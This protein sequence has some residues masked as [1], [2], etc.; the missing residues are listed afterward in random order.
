LDESNTVKLDDIQSGI[1][2]FIN[3]SDYQYSIFIDGEWGIGK[4][5]FIRNTLKSSLPDNFRYVYVSLFGIASI[6]ELD[7]KISTELLLQAFDKK[8]FCKSKLGKLGIMLGK[9]SI[10]IIL[11]RLALNS[12][13]FP[14]NSE[15]ASLLPQKNDRKF[16]F[17]FDDIERASCQIKD[18]FGYI[19]N[20]I[21]QYRAKVL[22]IGCQPKIGFTGDI[23]E[24]E[25]TKEHDDSSNNSNS[26]Q[27][28]EQN[29]FSQY[30]EKLIGYKIDFKPDF[31]DV[32]KIFVQSISNNLNIEKEIG[33]SS[34]E[35]TEVI[36]SVFID[37]NEYNLRKFQSVIGTIGRLFKSLI[38]PKINELFSDQ[39][40]KKQF[41][42]ISIIQIAFSKLGKKPTKRWTE[43]NLLWA[44]QLRSFPSYIDSFVKS[45]IMPQLQF[46]KAI[47]EFIRNSEWEKTN[48]S[49]PLNILRNGYHELENQQRLT[50]LY[51]ELLGKIKASGY[52]PYK[53]GDLLVLISKLEKET[54]INE[55][56]FLSVIGMLESQVK[57]IDWD[58]LEYKEFYFNVEYFVSDDTMLKAHQETLH[59]KF[60]EWGNCKKSYLETKM[61]EKIGLFLR[62]KDMDGLK[63]YIFENQNEIFINKHFLS[64]ID[65]ETIEHFLANATPRLYQGFRGAIFVI[66]TRFG[67][68]H[69]DELNL[70]NHIIEWCRENITEGDKIVLMQRKWLI[71]N[72][73][74]L[75][76]SGLDQSEQN[77]PKISHDV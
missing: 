73:R 64:L 66:Y 49:D 59:T 16:L 54:L 65:W 56:E 35:I 6:Q 19:N 7:E 31:L 4:T 62:N 14:S 27:G 17:V 37:V 34:V 53:W 9:T 48:Q 57:S 32:A 69:I 76:G 70:I 61:A 26:S 41:F 5:Y 45:S 43:T 50:E 46:R 71:D 52:P 21:E 8:E 33:V 29:I 58:S 72:L 24:A 25:L 55:G 77:N 67:V 2:E 22:L 10:N 74:E 13:D 20:F 36:T 44:L 68:M 51:S 28:K 23:N 12:N 47:D 11:K 63:E 42:M 38:N 60:S 40:S 75:D 1:L 30:G 15:W 3:S 39:A 18:L